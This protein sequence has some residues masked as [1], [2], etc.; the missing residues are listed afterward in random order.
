MQPK[1]ISRSNVGRA[2]KGFTLIELLVVIAIIAIL[3]AI[4]FPAFAK[5]R[6]AAR[7]SSCSSNMKQI[8]VALMQ[9]T[10][11]YDEKYP[12]GNAGDSI[13]WTVV[14]QP[15]LKSAQ[16][17]SCPSNTKNQ[18]FMQNTG[19][20]IPMSYAANGTNAVV[21]QMGGR[22]PINDDAN[23]SSGYGGGAALASIDAPA[24]LILVYE[25][26]GTNPYSIQYDLAN[27]AS[28]NFNFQNHLGTSNFL[29]GDGHVKSMRPTATG[30]PI[31]LWNITNTTTYGDP[32]PGPAN[33]AMMSWLN[34]EQT[35]M[36]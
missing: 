30:T 24:Q 35:L 19:N 29:F 12:I 18:T 1:M 27:L 33:A 3:A 31:N 5:A 4:L 25:N 15:Y 14:V 23:N 9:Y 20:T 26:S 2:N 21:N 34:G 13:A 36:Q 8:G 32:T 22:A 6:E 16:I 7:R 10:Q 17:F 28:N 11:E